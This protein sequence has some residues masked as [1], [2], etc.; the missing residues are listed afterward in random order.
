[1]FALYLVSAVLYL[2]MAIL[3]GRL[4]GAPGV[5]F[6]GALAYTPMLAGNWY[7]SRSLL[8][9]LRAQRAEALEAQGV[10]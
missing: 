7:V 8:R 4:W 6:G 2:P 5:I 9:E 10:G 1:M 3:G